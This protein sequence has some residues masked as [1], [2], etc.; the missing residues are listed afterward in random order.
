[1]VLVLL[2]MVAVAAEREDRLMAA[3]DLLGWL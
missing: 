3:L 1:M 2:D